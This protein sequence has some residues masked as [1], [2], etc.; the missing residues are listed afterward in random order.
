MRRSA[1]R[2]APLCVA[3]LAV[4]CS[5]RPWTPSVSVAFWAEDVPE[6]RAIPLPTAGEALRKWQLP[7]GDPYRPYVKPTLFASLDALDRK[8]T[9]LPDVEKLDVVHR[10][11]RAAQAIAAAGLPADVALV[12]DLRGAAS[13]AFGAELSRRSK[14]PVSLVPTFHNWP[15]EDELV[16]AEETLSALVTE[17]PRPPALHAHTVP[18]FLL[19]AWRLA[20]RFDAPEPGVFDNRYML[21]PT[22]L[23]DAS[24]FRAQGVH[25]VLYVVD[26][27][28]DTEVEEDDLHQAFRAFAVEGMGLSMVDL[29]WLE[30]HGAAPG[31]DLAWQSLPLRVEPRLTLVDDPLF[32][33]R[34]HGGFGGLG[35]IHFGGGLGH[36][37][38]AAG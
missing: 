11:R 24:A 34:A 9:L 19:D 1:T 17:E 7:P 3:I 25:R 10:A 30:E 28:D 16:P 37:G 2:V 23:P 20:Y 38:P 14:H 8:T 21:Q 22:D 15:A 35:G 31:L 6:G 36:I 27:F 26:S 12:V 4:G 5:L 13:V 29:A 18:V 32:Y 33:R